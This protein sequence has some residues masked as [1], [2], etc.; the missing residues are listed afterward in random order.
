MKKIYI[1]IIALFTISFA[2]A[3][4]LQEAA[5]AY[6]KEDYKK[7]ALI[8][9]TLADSVGVSP[10]LYYNLGNS[11]YKLKDY[12]KA[13]LNYERALL[14]LP[15][16]EDIRTNLEMARANITDKIDTL[17]KSFISVWFESVI[18]IASSNAW[19][20]FAIITF[21]IFLIGI[22]TY[23][24]T[25]NITIRKVG[26][27]GAVLMLILSL[28]ANIATYKQRD[29]IENRNHAIIMAPSIT[30]KSSPADSG[31]DLFILHEG[32]KVKVTDKVGDWSEIKIDDGNSGWIP[33][34]KMEII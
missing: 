17:D 26:F 24:F 30:V 16:D 4:S 19:A 32:T 28:F 3:Q 9:Q 23:I 11:Y 27:F 5:D 21:L 22:F 10:E 1:F 7:A 15:G 34:S 31:T 6:T 13:I 8:Y 25:K 33:S 29:K 2:S 14:M 12:P 18:N 20:L